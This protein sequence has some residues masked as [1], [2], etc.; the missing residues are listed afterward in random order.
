MEDL[1][2]EILRPLLKEWL[3]KNLP[4]L[5]ERLVRQEIEKMA[6]SVKDRL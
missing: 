3:D 5:I 4:D 1:V 2:K 6:G